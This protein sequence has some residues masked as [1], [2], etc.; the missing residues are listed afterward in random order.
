MFTG[1][2]PYKSQNCQLRFEKL[3][4]IGFG[5]SFTLIF[6]HHWFFCTRLYLSAWTKT[7]FIAMFCSVFVPLLCHLTLVLENGLK[8]RYVNRYANAMER[9]EKCLRRNHVHM[10]R[11]RSNL[12][13]VILFLYTVIVSVVNWLVTTDI[14]L[15]MYFTLLSV[16][17]SC[18]ASIFV[19][20]LNDLCSRFESITKHLRRLLKYS[21]PEVKS[22]VLHDLIRA[23]HSLCLSTELLNYIFTVRLT[24]LLFHF[25][26]GTVGNTLL[27]LD[28][29]LEARRSDISDNLLEQLNR[30]LWVIFYVFL[31][32]LLSIYPSVVHKKVSM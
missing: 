17:C 4:I 3:S 2:S 15:Y 23:H 5:L 32:S 9:I 29:L 19:T 30:I 26:A 24:V 21:N 25:F 28:I 20:Y 18:F 22:S 7:F 31:F 11:N 10:N 8:A 13:M 27:V 16:N 14:L 12:Y 6:V 1:I